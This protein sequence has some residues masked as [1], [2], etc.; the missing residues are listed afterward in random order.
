MG[1]NKN[2]CYTGICYLSC[3]L[4]KLSLGVIAL[5]TSILISSCYNYKEFEVYKI[6]ERKNKKTGRVEELFQNC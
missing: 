5:S 6:L 4:I 1:V 3:H 2:V